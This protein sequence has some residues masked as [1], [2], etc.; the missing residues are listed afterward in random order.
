MHLLEESPKKQALFLLPMILP[1]LAT[2]SITNE[3][4][5][6]MRRIFAIGS[7]C[8]GDDVG[9][10]IVPSHL[11][12]VLAGFPHVVLRAH[13]LILSKRFSGPDGAKDHLA[14]PQLFVWVGFG[15]KFP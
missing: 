4:L 3:A 8:Y 9:F 2:V 12:C 14:C 15:T 1:P 5:P 7:Y 10:D 13:C 11:N 6:F